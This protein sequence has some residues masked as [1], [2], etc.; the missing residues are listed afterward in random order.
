MPTGSGKSLCYQLPGIMQENKITIVFSPLLALIKDQMDHLTKLKICAESL[1]SKMTLTDRTRVINDLKSM[2]PATRFLYITPE[3]AATDFFRNL[4]DSIVKYNKLAYVAVDE[5]HCVSQWGHDFRKDYLRLGDLRK[6]YPTVTWIALTATASKDVTEDIFKNLALKEPKSFKTP[7]FRKNL[8]YDIIYK[9]S[10]QDDYIHLRDFISKCL[11]VKTEPEKSNDLPC[12]IIYCRTRDSVERVAFGLTKQSIISKAYHAGLKANDRKQVQEDWMNGKFP[13]IC[14]TNS[15]GMGVDKATVRFVV[16]WD[17]PQNIAAYYQES[18]RAGRDGKQSYCRLY[19]C[20][21]EVKSI[22]F[23]LNQDANKNPLNVRAKQSMKEFD[24]LVNHCE[25]VSCR[26]L[27]FTKYFGDDKEPDCKRRAQCDVCKDRKKVE[28]SLETFNQLSVSGFASKIQTDFDTSDMYGGG[29]KGNLDNERAYAENDSEFGESSQREEKAKKEAR[30]MIQKELERRRK[31]AEQAKLL[32]ENQ[33]RS[34]G[35]RVKN[36]IHSSKMVGLDTKKRESYLDFLVKKLKENVEK[37][38]EKL[39][40]DLRLCDFEDIGVEIEY[41]CFTN[42]K[43][44]TMYTRA[45]QKQRAQIDDCTKKKILFSLIRDHIPKKRKAHGGSAEDKQRQLQEF[46]KE[47]D[48][49]E[50]TK[51]RKETNNSFTETTSTTS[52]GT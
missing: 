7:C 38:T 6:R 3:Q 16:H 15:F 20:R 1:N 49:D 13:V 33:T 5:A 43:A 17:V 21:Q 9:N 10:I 24:K 12:G 47:H 22:S 28:K 50:P 44:L 14:A 25:S 29:R 46:M 31:Q 26:H 23:L 40:H 37:S 51:K 39:A 35:I 32:E 42:N 27:L 19:Y 45:V 41:Q 8:F 36:G 18:G 52:N 34:L 2:K 30:N 11:Q 48:I 4:L